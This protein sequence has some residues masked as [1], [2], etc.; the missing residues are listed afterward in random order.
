MVEEKNT[1]IILQLSMERKE[2]KDM[3]IFKWEKNR[4]WFSWNTF[5]PRHLKEKTKKPSQNNTPPKPDNHGLFFI[6][7]PIPT[8]N[9]LKTT[10]T[11]VFI[12]GEEFSVWL[13]LEVWTMQSIK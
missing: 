7:L 10:T 9:I 13:V 5:F 4:E 3:V 11:N 12:N 8:G 6:L 2:K 1:V